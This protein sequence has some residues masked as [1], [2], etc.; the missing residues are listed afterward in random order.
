M[1]RHALTLTLT[2]TLTLTLAL[3]LT[4]TRTST[5]PLTLTLTLTLTRCGGTP[6]LLETWAY[7]APTKGSDDL[8]DHAEFTSRLQEG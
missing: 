5:L 6:I 2:P 4:L 7:R 8:G 1:W 3:T